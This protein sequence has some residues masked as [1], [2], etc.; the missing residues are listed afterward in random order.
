MT[1]NSLPFPTLSDAV[2]PAAGRGARAAESLVMSAV[3]AL[4][5]QLEVVL[6]FTPVPLTGQT[7]GVLLA[8]VLLGSRWGALSAAFYLLEGAVGLPVFAGGGAGLLVFAGP[9]GGYLAGFLP[10]AWLAGTLA[11]RGWDRSPHTAAA[12]MLAGSAVLFA[13]GLLNLARFIPLPGL[14]AAGFWPFLPGDLLKAGLAAAAL[15][16]AWRLLGRR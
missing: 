4:G 13:C 14:L 7:F 1:E 15:P 6:P 12:A 3:I 2:F 9:T 8:G 5:A 11:E 10:A 16:G